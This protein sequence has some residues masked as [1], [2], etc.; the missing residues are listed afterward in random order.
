MDEL[1]F[2]GTGSAASLDRQMTSLCFHIGKEPFLI[3]CGDG[4]GTVRQIIR[5][6]IPLESVHTLF[7]T[8]HHAD[9]ILGIAH[10]LFVQLLRDPHM[11]ITIYGSEK[12]LHIAKKISFLTHEYTKIHS[13]NLYFHPLGSG[14][15]INLSGNTDVMSCTVEGHK[16]NTI[17]NY[18]YK[19]I[20]PRKTIVFSSDMQ[21]NAAFSRFSK[22][23]D[24]LI[25]ECYG[26]EKDKEKIHSFGHSTAEDAGILANQAEVEQLILTHLPAWAKEKDLS[27]MRQEAKKFYKGTTMVAEDLMRIEL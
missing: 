3:D 9:H 13:N 26:L 8:H 24:I 16:K 15:M 14:E 23:S 2:L 22:G 12:T 20:T 5:A 27:R 18:A 11:R 6:G 19:I 7:L 21:P 4:M 1:I 25:H 10:F 17:P